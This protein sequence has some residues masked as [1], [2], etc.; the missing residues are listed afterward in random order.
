M[1]DIE[2]TYQKSKMR[3]ERDLYKME[4]HVNHIKDTR[5]RIEIKHL[6]FSDIA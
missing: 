2:N 1:K 5:E 3:L 4:T 6:K